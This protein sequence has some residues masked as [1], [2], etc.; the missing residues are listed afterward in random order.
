M[1]ASVWPVHQWMGREELDKDELDRQRFIKKMN[2]Q[3]IQHIE[4]FSY[5]N[6]TTNRSRHPDVSRLVGMPREVLR[7]DPT[8]RLDD[9]ESDAP[10]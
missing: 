5:P 6:E 10:F 8:M 9:R 2:L 3:P 4:I 1:T 7:K